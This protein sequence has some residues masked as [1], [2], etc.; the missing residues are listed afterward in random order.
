MTS[1]YDT[2]R[3]GNHI[4]RLDKTITTEVKYDSRKGLLKKIVTVQVRK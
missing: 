1:N 4:L 3:L 2:D